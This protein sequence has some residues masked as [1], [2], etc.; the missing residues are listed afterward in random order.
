MKGVLQRIA[1]DFDNAERERCTNCAPS[2]S[3]ARHK[4]MFCSLG[5]QH[6]SKTGFLHCSD[7]LDSIGPGGQYKGRVEVT[8][9]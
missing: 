4:V 1:V 6:C 2:D 7:F 3:E 5:T 8:L 9:E